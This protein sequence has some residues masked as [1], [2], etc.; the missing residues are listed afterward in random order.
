MES[1]SYTYNSVDT[2]GV[3]VTTGI[4]GTE[5]FTSSTVNTIGERN[6]YSFIHRYQTNY[7]KQ[8]HAWY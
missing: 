5:D 7:Y 2:F 4:K 6:I 1:I 3:V 8:L